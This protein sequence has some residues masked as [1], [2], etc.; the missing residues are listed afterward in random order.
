MMIFA[1]L[2]TTTMKSAKSKTLYLSIQLSAFITKVTLKFSNC[3]VYYLMNSSTSTPTS[4]SSAQ[5]SPSHCILL[6]EPRI[7]SRRMPY[8]PFITHLY[9]PTCPTV[10]QSTPAPTTHPWKNSQKFKK[11]P[12]VS[13]AML[14]TVPIPRPSSRIFKY[15]LL[16]NCLHTAN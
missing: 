2:F 15:Y 10:Q 8:C 7:F 1:K 16:I 14:L 6:I 3:W 5:K 11:K 12:Y 9:T 4:T 13:S